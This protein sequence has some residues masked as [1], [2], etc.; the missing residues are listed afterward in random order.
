V[1]VC[2]Y[3]QAQNVKVFSWNIRMDTKN[4]GVD[5]WTNRKKELANFVKKEDP[6]FFGIQE[7]LSHQVKYLKKQ[8]KD[9]DYIGVGRD[10]GAQAGEF[11]ALFYKKKLWKPIKSGN[12]W[13]SDTPNLVSRGWDAACHRITTYGTFANKGKDTITVYNTHL[14]HQ[15]VLARTN[16]VAQL[17]QLI[18]ENK[19]PKILMGDFNF[20]PQNQ[21]YTNIS[22]IW[23]DSR[24]ATKNVIE[25]Q[26]GTVSF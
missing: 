18:N 11:M 5:Q 14:D 2:F 21:L 23:S 25:T 16:S 9:Y 24:L 20:N 10:D 6:D 12:F 8:L 13:L 1:K 17:N 3:T 26:E 15:G 4:D 19:Y 7:G 22:A